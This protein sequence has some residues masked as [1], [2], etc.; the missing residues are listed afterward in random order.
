MRT[1]TDIATEIKVKLLRQ[2]LTQRDVARTIGCHYQGVVNV[3]RGD[4]DT[5]Y[6]RQGIA[7]ILGVPVDE[8]WP[9]SCNE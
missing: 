3:I 1:S 2:G 4:R 9:E 5:A 7:D 8:L 6:I